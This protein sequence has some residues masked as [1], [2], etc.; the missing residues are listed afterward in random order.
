MIATVSPSIEN[1][2]HTLNTL[3]Y[4]QRLKDISESRQFVPLAGSKKAKDEL[5]SQMATRMLKSDPTRG[6]TTTQKPAAVQ[7][8]SAPVEE[9]HVFAVSDWVLIQNGKYA[10]QEGSVS[11]HGLGHVLYTSC[12]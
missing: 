8:N 7:E 6:T 12:P 5:Q 10:G 2:E 11:K 3:R 1:C 4:A 9:A